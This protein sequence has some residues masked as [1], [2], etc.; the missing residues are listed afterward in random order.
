MLSRPVEQAEEIGIGHDC[1]PAGLVD[2]DVLD[3]ILEGRIRDGVNLVLLPV[4]LG[5]RGKT[6]GQGPR[7]VARP[8]R[9]QF[10]GDLVRQGTAFNGRKDSAGMSE[11]VSVGG[12]V[13]A[14]DRALP[15]LFAERF[16]DG[17]RTD[18]AIAIP[19]GP[20]VPQ[21]HAVHHAGA[22]EPMVPVIVDAADEIRTVAQ[23]AAIQL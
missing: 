4:G 17:F 23:I 6:A 15:P 21:P 11:N 12:E 22:K 8:D 5:V 1:H 9:V 10:A 19:L 20:S 3:M 18:E 2:D 13:E 14:I 16:R 7:E